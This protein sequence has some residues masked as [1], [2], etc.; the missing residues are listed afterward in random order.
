MTNHLR[1]IGLLAA[2]LVCCSASAGP[3]SNPTAVADVTQFERHLEEFYNSAEFARH[4]ERGLEYYDKDLRFFDI[5][6]PV[7]YRGEQF[8]EHFLA[9]GKQFEGGKVEFLE[10]EVIA[11]PDMACATSLQHFA[12]KTPDG[13]PY[14]MTMRVTDFLQKKRDHWIITH[15][16][17]SLPLDQATFL[18]VINPK[19]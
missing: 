19:P 5:M 11:G 9:L 2:A 15:E 3:R 4:P 7:E 18:S 13:K 17:V 12:G 6:Q 1:S 10:L 14:D 8:K 16:H